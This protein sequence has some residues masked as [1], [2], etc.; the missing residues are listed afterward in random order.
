MFPHPQSRKLRI[1]RQ[2]LHR[3]SLSECQMS[4]DGQLV[5]ADLHNTRVLVQGINQQRIRSNH[6]LA[7]T[8]IMPGQVN[9]LAL[10]DDIYLQVIR[11]YQKQ[12]NAQ[13]FH[14]A[15]Q[16]LLPQLGS[17]AVNHALC[18]FVQEFPPQVVSQR[19]VAPE[20][21]LAGE[22]DGVSNR[23]IVMREMIRLW[24]N[25]ANSAAALF[26]ELF[27]D[28]ELEKGS[29]YLHLKL[30]ISSCLPCFPYPTNAWIASIALPGF[31]AG[32]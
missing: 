15:Y 26:T 5:L 10:I 27:D 11:L 21:Y 1:S 17:Q 14:Q 31:Q 22:T 19:Q 28:V 32:P 7:G 4:D 16:W 20:V 30:R 9:A 12:E 29:P 18:T 3:Y 23:E 24:L 25:N 13:I 2:A 8:P 6:P